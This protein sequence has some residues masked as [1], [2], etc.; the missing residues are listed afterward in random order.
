MIVKANKRQKEFALCIVGGM[1][2][3]SAAKAVGY[4][5]KHCGRIR[6]GKGVEQEIRQLRREMIGQTRFTKEFMIE[7]LY[8]MMGKME[9][10][11]GN[12]ESFEPKDQREAMKVALE[13]SREINKM[14]G[15]YTPVNSQHLR[16]ESSAS[17]MTELLEKIDK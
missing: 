3:W 2:N 4:L 17:E 7:K 16:V 6:R 14:L 10:A 12:S 13:I 9:S 15:H 11:I 8:T 5:P 1:G